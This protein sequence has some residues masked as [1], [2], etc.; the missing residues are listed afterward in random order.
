ML[1]VS[2]CDLEVQGTTF[3]DFSSFTDNSVVVAKQVDLMSK[4]GFAKMT[5]RYGFTIEVKKPYIGS[6]DLDSITDG[7]LSVEYDS[8]ERILYKGV[9]TI[10][11]GDQTTDGETETTITKTF[12]ATDKVKEN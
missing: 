9:Q 6:I 1:Y 12:G 10:E 4:T 7:T 5:P 3:S 8:G 11:T 2:K